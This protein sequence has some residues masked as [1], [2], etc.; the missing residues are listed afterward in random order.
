MLARAVSDGHIRRHV[1]QTCYRIFGF[2]TFAHLITNQ[3]EMPH[4]CMPRCKKCD[5][6][7]S[8][9]LFVWLC[10]YIYV[11]V[12]ELMWLP[13]MMQGPSRCCDLRK[14]SISRKT[15]TRII[16]TFPPIEPKTAIAHIQKQKN[17]QEITTHKYIHTAFILTYVLIEFSTVAPACCNARWQLVLEVTP[18]RGLQ[19]VGFVSQNC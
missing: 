12:C 16:N 19:A 2:T 17:L 1:V 13:R 8:A 5:M 3:R 4:C 9:S 14:G 11:C 10:I 15:L 6:F 18:L 7:V